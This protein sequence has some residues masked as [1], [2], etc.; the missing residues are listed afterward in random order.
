MS[1][2]QDVELMLKW[3]KDPVAFI[4]F[5]W[6]LIPQQ[7]K[8]EHKHIKDICPLKD[9]TV[10]M[11]EPF[12]KDKHITWQQWL[13]CEA[14]KRTLNG[15]GQKRISIES[16]HGTGKSAIMS[17]I[18]LWYLFCFYNC[19]VGC[20][21]PTASQM[22]DVLWKECAKWIKKMPKPVA[23]VF[24]WTSN[25]IRIKDEPE[26]WFARAKTA[27]K[28]SPE[29]LAGIHGKY[30]L[31]A[32]DEASGVAEEVFKTAEGAL[33]NKNILVI[34][35]SNHT[36]NYGT[37]HE[38]HTRDSHN[39]Q[40][41]SFNS[42]ES[43][44]VDNDFIDRMSEKY[45]QDSDE[46]RIRVLGKSPREETIDDGGYVPLVSNSEITEVEQSNFIGRRRLS[47]DVSG[48]G[49]D[50]T[51]WVLRD[52]FKAQIVGREQISN[53]KSVAQKTLTL[54]EHF[55]VEAFDV[56]VDNFG[57]GSKTVHE[58]ASLGHI[59]NAIDVSDKPEEDLYLNIRAEAYFALR[60]WLKE[61]GEL[62]YD[63]A[64]KQLE[65]IRYRRT[66]EKN[67]RIQI[68]PKKEMKKQGFNSPDE[69]DALMLSFIGGEIED[70][71]ELE[72]EIN[73]ESP[74]FAQIGV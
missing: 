19:Q 27:K 41:L 56:Y 62:V 50:K 29:A 39:Y 23:N 38:S 74:M 59:V 26:T 10:D 1:S 60:K 6:G 13:V 9:F 57:V 20:T 44:I 40:T 71:E 22:H 64:W 7:L 66:G 72:E 47:I 55:E 69:A 4:S 42:M 65:R 12:I 11:F 52:R 63:E 25:Y 33:T 3:K 43:P 32:V 14:I 61:G 16:G 49:Q 37:F 48:E 35:V 17:M 30:V 68:M 31:F 58:L 45:G 8:Q 46:F 51:I 70:I 54:M 15:Q 18:I 34:L 24:D 67:S 28:E 36:R 73:D 2:K 53:P 21:A 5:M